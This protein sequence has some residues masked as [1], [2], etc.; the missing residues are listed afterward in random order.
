MR[1]FYKAVVMVIM[2]IWT[3]V[4]AP[5]QQYKPSSWFKAPTMDWTHHY[6]GEEKRL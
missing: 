4:K 3:H 1:L 5:T 6:S 2:T